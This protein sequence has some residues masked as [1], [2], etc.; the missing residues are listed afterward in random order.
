[1]IAVRPD[2]A[3]AVLIIVLAATAPA[4]PSNIIIKPAKYIDASPKFLLSLYKDLSNFIDLKTILKNSPNI[5]FYSCY[6]S[7]L[8]TDKSIINDIKSS[9][10]DFDILVTQGAGS[11]SL[12]C[13]AIKTKW[14]I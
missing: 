14:Q 8:Y 9:S 12:I 4:I 3:I 11:V 7:V 1:M 13:A 2:I 5:I 10:N 6:F